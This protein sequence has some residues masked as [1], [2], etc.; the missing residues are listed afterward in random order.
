MTANGANPYWDDTDQNAKK[1]VFPG[2][3]DLEELANTRTRNLDA[4]GEE[5]FEQASD[6]VDEEFP[7]V[8]I[9]NITESKVGTYTDN[10]SDL[11]AETLAATT[12]TPPLQVTQGA[13]EDASSGDN[14]DD[15]PF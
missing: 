1:W 3:P 4:D 10:A 5:D 2:R 13:D 7:R 6:L 11:G 12:A 14:Y 8:T 9:S 15:L